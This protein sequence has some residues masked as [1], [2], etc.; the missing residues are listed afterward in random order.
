[1]GEGSR[2]VYCHGSGDVCAM[3]GHGNMAWDI[4]HF[5]NANDDIH[6]SREI[7]IHLD[8]IKQNG[9][10]R[11]TSVFKPSFLPALVDMDLVASLGMG[12]YTLQIMG[13]ILDCAWET[14]EPQKNPLNTSRE[15]RIHLDR[16]KQN[17]DQRITSVIHRQIRCRSWGIFWTVHGRQ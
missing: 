8:R 15:I 9:D 17:G 6:T 4:K 7:R 16:I 5:R 1:M 10:Q 14:V 13:Y 12:Y 11:I 2:K 3:D